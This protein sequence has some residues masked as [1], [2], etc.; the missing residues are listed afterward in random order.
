MLVSA[1]ACVFVCVCVC[2]CVCARARA[3]RIVSR[4]NILR[5][6]NTSIKNALITFVAYTST[7]QCREEHDRGCLVEWC[8]TST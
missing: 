5:F 7:F 3:L 6:K 4:D 1:G 8:F 2:V